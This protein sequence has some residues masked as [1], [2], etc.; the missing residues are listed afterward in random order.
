MTLNFSSAC[1]FANTQ[2]GNLFQYIYWVRFY[3]RLYSFTTNP[4][5]ST[6]FSALRYL[7][8]V[9][10]LCLLR[11]SSSSL[12]T[13][14]NPYKDREELYCHFFYNYLACHRWYDTVFIL[15]SQFSAFFLNVQLYMYYTLFTLIVWY[16]YYHSCCFLASHTLHL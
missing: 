5:S 4:P 1:V 14:I 8:A 16:S 6:H 13:Q 7:R 9:Q 12:L 2:F 3:G 10:A 15:H 11:R